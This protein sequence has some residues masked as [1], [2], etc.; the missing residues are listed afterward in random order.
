MPS[1][2]KGNKPYEV[3]E[4]IV[5]KYREINDVQRAMEREVRERR[6]LSVGLKSIDKKAASAYAQEAKA[7]YQ[8]YIKYSKDHKVA[9]YPDRCRV[10]DGEELIDKKYVR[11]LDAYKKNR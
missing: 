8:E 9:Y 4:K 3:S 7:W 5:R 10:F 6:A 11:L 2:R 1:Y